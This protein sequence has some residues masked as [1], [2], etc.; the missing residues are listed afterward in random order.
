MFSLTPEHKII[1]NRARHAN[2]LK[3]I[4][5]QNTRFHWFLKSHDKRPLLPYRTLHF[6]WRARNFFCIHDNLAL[7]LY[8]AAASSASRLCSTD[9][10][11][12]YCSRI[13]DD[14]DDV[15][16]LPPQFQGIDDTY[17]KMPPMKI[18]R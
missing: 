17:D 10:L 8:K 11:I 6:L 2:L 4:T 5:H 18:P 1:N 12:S 16:L 14:N 9:T 15:N 7:R 3:D 13:I